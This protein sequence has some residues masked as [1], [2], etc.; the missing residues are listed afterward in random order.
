MSGERRPL[1]AAVSGSTNEHLI[2]TSSEVIEAVGISK[3]RREQAEHYCAATWFSG[4]QRCALARRVC[5]LLQLSESE[6]STRQP[7]SGRE[8]DE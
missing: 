4:N 7:H 8:G 3:Q 6:S 2:A 1:P 5:F